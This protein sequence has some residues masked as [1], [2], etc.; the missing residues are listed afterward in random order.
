ML[1]YASHPTSTAN[2]G[3][4]SDNQKKKEKKLK[5]SEENKKSTA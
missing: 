3:R 5:K 4:I 2:V 1:Q